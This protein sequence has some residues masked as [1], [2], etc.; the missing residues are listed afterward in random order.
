[1]FCPAGGVSEEEPKGNQP[2]QFQR[3]LLQSA[4]R[5]AVLGLF[6]PGRNLQGASSLENPSICLGRLGKARGW[7]GGRLD[8]PGTSSQS[9]PC[10]LDARSL[11]PSRRPSLDPV[12]DAGSKGYLKPRPGLLTSTGGGGI[13][14][15]PG[16]LHSHRDTFCS[17]DHQLTSGPAGP[18]TG[19][20]MALF[21]PVLVYV[22]LLVLKFLSSCP[23]MGRSPVRATPNIHDSVWRENG[24][25]MLHLNLLAV[26][27]WGFLCFLREEARGSPGQ[28]CPCYWLA[29]RLHW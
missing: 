2:R 28:Q 14:E 9:G 13:I 23:L 26:V 21:A 5:P 16:A 19:P 10:S 27:W 7:A 4:C 12:V 11:V 29:G 15:L 17:L 8:P 20:S 3:R 6:F 22:P 25:H 24:R 1:M 18:K